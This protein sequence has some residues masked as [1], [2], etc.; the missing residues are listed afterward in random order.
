MASVGLPISHTNTVLASRNRE[1]CS[2]LSEQGVSSGRI[3]NKMLAAHLAGVAQ[4]VEHLF[5]KQA[6]RGS[7][8]LASSKQK[9]ARS[10][11]ENLRRVARV[12]KG[13]GL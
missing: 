10:T 8:P 9:I 1:R 5:C 12:A 4:P 3:G 7:S 2:R 13:S 11:Y 6:V